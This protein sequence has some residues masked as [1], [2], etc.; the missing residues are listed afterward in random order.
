MITYCREKLISLNKNLQ[1][2]DHSMKVNI[3]QFSDLIVNTKENICTLFKVIKPQIRVTN[4]PRPTRKNRGVN[5]NNLR[6]IDIINDEK[7][8]NVLNSFNLCVLN[9]QSIRNKT[10]ELQEYLLDNDLD[11]F[12][13]AET[14]LK[15]NDTVTL[16]KLLP[17]NYSAITEN[18]IGRR[19]GGLAV[20]HKSVL[21]TSKK[22]SPLVLSHRLSFLTYI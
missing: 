16:H 4:K 8:G 2:L 19:G 7:A 6:S 1:C 20:I 18:R 9:C 22:I 15:P 14:W 10:D 12:V 3:E 17:S 13:A 5:H 21:E 11:I